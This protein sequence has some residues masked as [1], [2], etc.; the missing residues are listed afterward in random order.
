MGLLYTRY[1]QIEC[2]GLLYESGD[3]QAYPSL[4][5]CQFS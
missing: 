4:P 2:S 1:I 5:W 3:I